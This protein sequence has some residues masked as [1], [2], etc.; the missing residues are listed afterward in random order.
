[1][2]SVKDS[3]GNHERYVSES[4]PFELVANPP[5]NKPSSWQNKDMDSAMEDWGMAPLIEKY[6]EKK[7][8]EKVAEMY[9][10]LSGGMVVTRLIGLNQD[11]RGPND[12]AIVHVWIGANYPLFRH[13][14]PAS[15]DSIYYV[16][17]GELMLGSRSLGPGSG[18]FLPNGMPYKYSGGPDGCELL[19]IRVGSGIPDTP[20][21][22]FRESSLDSIQQIIDKANEN[23]HKWQAPEKIGDTA[24]RQAEALLNG[25]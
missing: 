1:M 10:A 6:G 19:E 7:V 22:V 14:H 15:G 12:M 2:A 3:T 13:A 11:D 17:A 9:K 5:I 18:F 8:R 4:R 16:I 24:L 23:R 21:I 25:M 20:I